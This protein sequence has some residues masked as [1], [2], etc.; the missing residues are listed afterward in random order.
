MNLDTFTQIK[1]DSANLQPGKM[2]VGAKCVN[3]SNH[4]SSLDYHAFNYPFVCNKNQSVR[5]GL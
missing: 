2:P 3:I 1:R 4:L 5:N